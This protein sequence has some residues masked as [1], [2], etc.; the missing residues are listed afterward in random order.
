MHPLTKTETELRIHSRSNVFL[1]AVLDGAGSRPVRVRNLSAG[2]ALVEGAKLPAAGVRASLKRGSLNAPG[3]IAWT[4][5]QHCGIRFDEAADVDEWIQR[6][7]PEHQQ[8]ID[9]VI[10]DYRNGAV[11][12]SRIA[13]VKGPNLR[14]TLEDIGAELMQIAERI[15]NLPDLSLELAEELVRIEAAA[16]RIRSS[17]R[18]TG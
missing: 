12:S 9:E 1:M 17:S 6:V 2:G 14:A 10:D 5:G 11:C 16:H 8:R 13:L 15:S 7:G 18:L 3:E 4:R